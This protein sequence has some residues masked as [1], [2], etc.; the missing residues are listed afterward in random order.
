MQEF[1]RPLKLTKI[2]NLVGITPR[3][4]RVSELMKSLA[5][6]RTVEYL[7]KIGISATNVNL[8]PGLIE[9]AAKSAKRQ[10][11]TKI[12]KWLKVTFLRMQYNW[13]YQKLSKISPA[14]IVVWNGQKGY[15]RIVSAA[16]KATGNSTIFLE[17]APLPGRITI[18][19][20]GVNA[21]SNLPR[22]P[23]FFK[24][25]HLSNKHIPAETWREITPALSSRQANDRND[26]KQNPAA[27]NL[28]DIPYIFVPLQVPGD[29]Q[30]TIFG[31]WIKSMEHFIDQVFIAQK[32]LPDNW[33][34][35]IKEHP[36]A[37]YSLSNFI[38]KKS[39][40]RIKIDNQTDTLE[41]VASAQ[42]VMTLNSSVG[43]EAIFF[44]KPVIILGDAF[45]DVPG[46]VTRAKSL[47]ELVD[48]M[49]QP[50]AIK[51]EREIRDA[52]MNYVTQV[53]F[54]VEDEV[55]RG[56]Y[57]IEDVIQRDEMRA[58]ILNQIS[59]IQKPLEPARKNYSV[60]I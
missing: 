45:Y 9:M 16:A 54:P 7:E 53:H 20:H 31:D 13:S 50:R 49:K 39:A 10:Y 51:F 1:C 24:A 57:T 44:D 38:S 18:D 41:Q 37:R 33:Y 55:L 47:A 56:R 8:D 32:Y 36:S 11:R 21:A 30:I 17:E 60:E 3:N 34:I 22:L 14:F 23:E 35:R 19:F 15:R 5:G 52:F 26:V 40:S 27:S 4:K 12:N 43:F 58:T 25:W 2:Q 46:V 59:A 29:S 42:A 48:Y 28:A 6:A